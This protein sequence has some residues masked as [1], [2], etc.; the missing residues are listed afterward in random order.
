MDLS[1]AWWNTSLSPTYRLR[2]R[3]TDGEIATAAGMLNLFTSSNSIDF[4]ALCEVSPG[5][6][7]RLQGMCTLDGYAVHRAT[8]SSG[9]GAAFDM[10]VLYRSEKLA[11]AGTRSILSRRGYQTSRVAQHL[12]FA[13]AGEPMPFHVFLSHWPSR[14]Q[15]QQ[16]EPNRQLL[17]TRLR[18]AIDEILEVEQ[19]AKI[20]LVGDYNDEPFDV[21][22][23]ERVMAS[24]DKELV[25]RRKH[26]FYN[27]FWR[28]LAPFGYLS[29]DEGK[30]DRGSYFHKAGDLTRWRT[31]DQMMFSSTF[32]GKGDWLLNESST[33]VFEVQNY[34]SLVTGNKARFDH[35]PIIGHIEKKVAKNG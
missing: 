12:I 18:Y 11:L 3:A 15:L 29:G 22:I 33:R 24:R 16:H 31:F 7:D 20:I 19:D 14:L 4:V 2:D 28:H 21:S 27:P 17:G 25:G 6:I 9:R 34:T 26:L 5:D 1:L 23:S 8:E 30:H 32:V 10:C 13:V 35:L